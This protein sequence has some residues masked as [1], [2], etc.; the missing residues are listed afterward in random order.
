MRRFAIWCA[1][2]SL[3]IGMSIGLVLNLSLYPAAFGSPAATRHSD[4]PICSNVPAGL[5]PAEQAWISEQ[6]SVRTAAFGDT[7]D[8][9][10]CYRFSKAITTQG[11]HEG[12]T[13]H[14]EAVTFD[15]V[16]VMQLDLKQGA[17]SLAAQGVEAWMV[18][19]RLVGPAGKVPIFGTLL[20]PKGITNDNEYLL[21][22][23]SMISMSDLD[24]Y[25]VAARIQSGPRVVDSTTG[26]SRPLSEVESVNA[27]WGFPSDPATLY[28]GCEQGV[29]GGVDPQC[30]KDAYDIYNIAV[31]SARERYTICLNAVLAVM[32]VCV[33]GCA[34][35]A[36]TIFGGVVCLVSCLA[37]WTIGIV[38]CEALLRVD[39]REAEAQLRIALRACGVEIMEA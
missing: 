28:C 19:G 25:A 29:G 24:T 31:Q 14:N 35:L 15:A 5:T 26:V 23:A 4:G 12:L 2:R 36:V 10:T 18:V 30:V 13:I 27:L 22:V 1:K 38:A 17:A 6:C 7:A 33:A 37:V 32:A 39:M 9:G 11:K 34:V 3:C 16:Y 20:L 8:P 21:F